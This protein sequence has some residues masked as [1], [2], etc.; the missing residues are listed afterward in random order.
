MNDDYKKALG[1]G[2]FR[3]PN[4]RRL[5]VAIDFDNTLTTSPKLW[6]SIMDQLRTAGFDVVMVTNRSPGGKS[7]A[8]VRA[9]VGNLL[10]VVFAAGEYKKE[11]AR[12]RGFDV[13]IWIDDQPWTIQEPPH[14][15]VGQLGR[16]K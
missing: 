11:A 2:D 5:V 16:K 15:L 13:S 4:R 1:L 3:S 9:L 14:M 6:L 10:P 12:K 7:E 8:E